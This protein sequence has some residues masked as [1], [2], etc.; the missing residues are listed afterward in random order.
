MKTRKPIRRSVRQVK[1]RMRVPKKFAA[2]RDAI[3]PILEPY[4]V[5]RI[6]LF[7]SFVRGEE[8]KKSDIDILV[9]FEEPRRRPLGLFKWGEL[10]DELRKRLGRKVDLVS[11]VALNKYIRPYVEK[12]MVILYDAKR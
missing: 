9:D 12:E 1:K 10:E 11:S 3:L 6:A 7:G 2:W 4:G 8:T 5:K